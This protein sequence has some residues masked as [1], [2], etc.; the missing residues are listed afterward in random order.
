MYE[1]R[2]GAMRKFDLVLMVMMMGMWSDER[3]V[4][5]RHVVFVCMFADIDV[6]SG[7]DGC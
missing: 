1:L 3:S 5:V 4:M 6:M 2:C 7:D